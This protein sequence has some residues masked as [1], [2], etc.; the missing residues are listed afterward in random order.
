[1]FAERYHQEITALLNRIHREELPRIQQAADLALESVARGGMLHLFGSGHSHM[2]CEEVFRRA[3]GLCC[4]NAIMDPALSGHGYFSSTLER[5]EG[6]VPTVLGQFDLRP[7]ETL[8]VISNSGINAA[9]VEAALYAKSKG[10]KVVAI[11]SLT[12][13]QA[14][15][16]RVSGGQK[17]YQVSDVVLDTGGPKGDAVL[18]SEQLPAPFCGTSTITG[19]FIINCLMAC[20]V[21][22]LLQRGQTPSIRLS[23][24]V[25]HDQKALCDDYDRRIALQGN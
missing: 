12:H 23:A 4:V 10:L 25:P 20:I 17:L 18:V 9:P 21:E 16:S 2:V 5:L 24:N 1:M 22:G 13:S 14:V 11:T 7:G 3:G 19:A 6:Y 15:P 8:V